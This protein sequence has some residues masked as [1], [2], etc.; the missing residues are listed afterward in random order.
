MNGG[1]PLAQ[2][3]CRAVRGVGGRLSEVEVEHLLSQLAEGWRLGKHGDVLEREFR[4]EDFRE[5]MGFVNAVAWMAECENHHPELRVRYN[6][7]AVHYST[8]DVGG[9][10]ENDFICAARIDALIAC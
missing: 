5:T 9:L 8:H 2:R 3:H 10:S 7:C 1:S 6:A 4:F